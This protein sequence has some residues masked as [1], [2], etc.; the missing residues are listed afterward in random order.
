MLSEELHQVPGL[1]VLDVWYFGIGP[2][3]LGSMRTWGW[4]VSLLHLGGKKTGRVASWAAFKRRVSVRIASR[5]GL[6]HG[7]ERALNKVYTASCA[8]RCPPPSRLSSDLHF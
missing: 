5:S 8:N 4:G 3:R 1:L 2:A 7:Q 6:G